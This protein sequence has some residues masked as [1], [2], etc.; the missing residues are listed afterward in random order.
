MLVISDVL[1][2]EYQIQELAEQII[3]QKKLYY[4]KNLNHYLTGNNAKRWYVTMEV[5]SGSSFLYLLSKI[6]S[7]LI[8]ECI[9]VFQGRDANLHTTDGWR[10]LA[11][12]YDIE[13][14]CHR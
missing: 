7:V 8:T 6:C 10:R 13:V 5:S 3:Y 14:L 1:V 9:I 12:Q 2:L 11:T 4:R